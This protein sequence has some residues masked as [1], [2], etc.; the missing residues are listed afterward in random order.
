MQEGN[1]GQ[2]LE[3]IRFNIIMAV[4]LLILSGVAVSQASSSL[5]LL[6]LS[7]VFV[8]EWFQA[9]FALTLSGESRDRLRALEPFFACTS[10][11]VVYGWTVDT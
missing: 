6:I 8:P 10:A 9:S 3:I 11:F 1:K 5:I 4:Y 7:G 2:N